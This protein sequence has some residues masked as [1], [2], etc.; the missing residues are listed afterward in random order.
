VISD[1]GKD[2]IRQ[3]AITSPHEWQRLSDWYRSRGL[4]LAP[5]PPDRDGIA[6]YSPTP[7]H[8]QDVQ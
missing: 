4:D 2:F 5:M 3:L 1:D 6:T 8:G 7:S